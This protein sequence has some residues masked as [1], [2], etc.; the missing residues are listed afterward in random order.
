VS[1]VAAD[2]IIERTKGGSLNA[3][4]YQADAGT[5]LSALREQVGA[6]AFEV[7][8]VGIAAAFQP[9]EV[10]RPEVHGEGV[11]CE[12]EPVDGM[13]D[14]ALPREEAGPAGAVLGLWRAGCDGRSPQGWRSH[15]QL[16]R[17]LGAYLSQLPLEGAQPEAFLRDLWEASE[18]LGLL[19][20]ALSA[21][22]EAR[23]SAGVQGEASEG[24][25]GVWKAS[26]RWRAMRAALHAAETRDARKAAE[27]QARGRSH[28]MAVRRLLPVECE[29]LQGLPDGFTLVAYRAKPAADGPRYKAIGNGWCRPV[30][31]WVFGRLT[32]V[33]EIVTKSAHYEPSRS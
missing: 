13:D 25:R 23:R 28:P 29:R 1:K 11:R 3:T 18:G 26:A 7:W 32:V 30:F 19:R 21:A 24:V 27:N 12:A 17:E 33:D 8:G 20:Q 4:T 22:Q 31:E 2:G 16:A 9:E 5:L 10:L 14:D 6:E 15:E